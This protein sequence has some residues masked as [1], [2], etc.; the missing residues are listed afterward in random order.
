MVRFERQ[1]LTRRQGLPGWS[2]RSGNTSDVW[3]LAAIVLLVVVIVASTTGCG[4]DTQTSSSTTATT[5]VAGQT[6]APTGGPSGPPSGTG[7]PG[8]PPTGGTSTP[9]TAATSIGTASTT[10]TEAQTTTTMAAEGTYSDGIYLVGTDIDSGLYQGTVNGD[11][12]QW[13]ISSDAN[14]DR[15]VAS[16]DP[17]GPFY[18][19]VAYG[20]YLRLSGATIEEASS[21]AVDPLVTNN[22]TDGT[23]RV[24]YDIAT[25]WYNGTVNGS[26]GYWEISSDANGQTLVANEYPLDPFKLKV[27]SGQY[28]TLR[29]VT[30]SQ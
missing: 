2:R 13:E 20:Q 29:G 3:I 23:Y 11:K 27:A 14:G 17:T 21:T 12:G 16:G 1:R 19:K 26:M 30:V 10:T 4:S 24:G 15:F 6:A 9:T 7:G 22:I 25:G 5:A 28:L 8:M 18:V